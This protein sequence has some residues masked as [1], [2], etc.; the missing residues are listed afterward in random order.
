M[1]NGYLSDVVFETGESFL[2]AGFGV[3]GILLTK[4]STATGHYCAIKK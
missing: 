2:P 4:I 3:Q 1:Q